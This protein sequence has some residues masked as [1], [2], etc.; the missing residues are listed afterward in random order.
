M[1]AAWLSRLFERLGSARP[2]GA[3]RSAQAER[4]DAV[5]ARRASLG[6]ASALFS[7]LGEALGRGPADDEAIRRLAEHLRGGFGTQSALR[8]GHV[9]EHL[10]LWR[11]VADESGHP[12]A[13]GFHADTLLACGRPAE[14]MAEF[15]RAFAVDPTLL[16]E[17]G[18]E[19][20]EVTREL[21]GVAWLDYRVACLRAA[22]AA[23]PGPLPDDDEIRELYGE[24]CD[25]HADDAEAL[26]R[27]REVGRQIDDAVARG[28]L[29]RAMVRRRPR[30]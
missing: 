10:A 14:A 5:W 12:H 17:F 19:L 30:R 26:A 3:A 25:D 29:P 28:D 16:H 15:A 8:G 20:Y 6:S 24:L 18:D 1:A 23:G 7:A 11:R 22:L 27:I 2:S 21:G 4:V 9:E 13:R